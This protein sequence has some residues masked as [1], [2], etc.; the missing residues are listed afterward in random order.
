VVAE[1]ARLAAQAAQPGSDLRGSE[2]YK[3]HIVE[4]FVRRG[5]ARALEIA[6]GA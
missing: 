1:T 4:V 2:D 5:V 3:R 6:R